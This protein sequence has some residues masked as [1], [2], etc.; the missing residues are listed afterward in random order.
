MSLAVAA[1]PPLI[2]KEVTFRT[3]TPHFENL[4][5]DETNETVFFR[6]RLEKWTQNR[7]LVAA[8]RLGLEHKIIFFS[9]IGIIVTKWN[10]PEA[11]L[12]SKLKGLERQKFSIRK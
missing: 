6:I 10:R 1:R 12:R 9:D 11:L 2:P 7:P 3:I 8:F 4:E 5:T